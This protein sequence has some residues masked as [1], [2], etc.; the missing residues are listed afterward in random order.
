MIDANENLP[1]ITH[2]QIWDRDLREHC[3]PCSDAK[4]GDSKGPTK[5]IDSYLHCRPILDPGDPLQVKVEPYHSLSNTWVPLSLHSP[6]KFELQ[7][8][9]DAF[10]HTL[11]YPNN[12]LSSER[13]Y[14]YLGTLPKFRNN[15]K[16]LEIE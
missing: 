11:P 12:T 10:D 1:T 14:H 2:P 6:P 4:S 5:V 13:E 15:Q 16:V 9:L 3:L 7:P 8:P